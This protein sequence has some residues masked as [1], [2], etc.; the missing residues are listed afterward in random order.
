MKKRHYLL[1][2]HGK[3]IP[4]Y[5]EEL[6]DENIVMSGETKELLAVLAKG[7]SSLEKRVKE[8]ETKESE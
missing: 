5:L 3:D 1:Y 2:F 7:L 4:S 6:E 8:L